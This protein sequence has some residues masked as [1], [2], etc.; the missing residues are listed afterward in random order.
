ME[1]VQRHLRRRF[2]DGL[3]RDDT[4]TVAR[5]RERHLESRFNFPDDPV[6]ARS[7][8]LVFLQHALGGEIGSDVRE[9]ERCTV[10]LSFN[11]QRIGTRHDDQLREE[12]RDALDDVR[13]LELFVCVAVEVTVLLLSVPQ[14]AL[15]V[16]G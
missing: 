12:F 13:N 15:Q 10:S 4:D 3:R 16:D 5:W 11:R 1:R 7:C 2:S 6:E 14:D 8:E 9:E